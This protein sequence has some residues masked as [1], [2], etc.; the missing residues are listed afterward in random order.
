[1]KLL[2]MDTSSGACSAALYYDGEIDNE[3]VLDPRG[4][5]RLILPMVDKLLAKAGCT[6]S[7]LDGIAYG[8]GPGSFTGLRICSGIVQGLAYGAD[9]G[10][11]PVSTLETLAMGWVRRNPRDAINKTIVAAIDARMEEVYWCAYQ[12]QNE[13]LHALCVERVA[14]PDTVR[15]DESDVGDSDLVG[16]GDG[17]ASYSTMM[18]SAMVDKDELALPDAVDIIPLALPNCQRGELLA[19][20]QALPVYLR[21]E[22]SWK[23]RH[24]QPGY[25]FPTEP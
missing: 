17:W 16:V 13:K 25:T 24:E 21:N 5:T 11:I 6:L 22:V 7:A 2:A 4:H 8:R 18:H 12:W 15:I 3:Y 14:S 20:E 19:P 9:L 1:M 10:V 23:K